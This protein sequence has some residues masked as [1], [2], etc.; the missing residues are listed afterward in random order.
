[1]D[2]MKRLDELLADHETTLFDLAKASDINYSTL[3]TAKKRGS[4]LSVD[5]IER[6]CAGLGIR[7][8]EFFMNDEDCKSSVYQMYRCYC[9]ERRKRN[10]L[11]IARL[12]QHI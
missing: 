12:L 2:T 9:S 5:T 3:H 10:S 4:Q 8:F 6:I 7:P 11:R 1:M